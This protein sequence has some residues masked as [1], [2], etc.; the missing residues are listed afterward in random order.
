MADQSNRVPFDPR[1]FVEDLRHTAAMISAPFDGEVVRKIVA[2]FQEDLARCVVQ[3]KTS[4]DPLDGLYF[5]FFYVGSDSLIDRADRHGLRR[6]RPRRLDLFQTRLMEAYPHAMQAGLDFHCAVG[7]AK[8]WTYLGRRPMDELTKLSF[9]PESVRRHQTF[10]ADHGLNECFFL[11]VDYRHLT[12]NIYTFLDPAYRTSSWLEQMLAD[13]WRTD[14]E[15]IAPKAVTETLRAAACVGMTFSWD[16]PAMHRWALYGLNVRYLDA[17]ACRLLPPLPPR[18]RT[19]VDTAPTL[20][21]EPHLNIAW[22]FERTRCVTKFEKS[23]AN[24]LPASSATAD[25]LFVEL[26]G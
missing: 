6:F 25:P 16:N 5:R 11:A 12:I 26:A 4:S 13:T 23:Y 20:S 2:V 10:F 1:V 7:L 21:C 17:V 15:A 8:L 3:L 18:L 19:F 9:M 24:A 22:S 14:A